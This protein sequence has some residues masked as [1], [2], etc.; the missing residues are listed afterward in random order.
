MKPVA[1]SPSNENRPRTPLMVPSV[2]MNFWKAEP[3]GYE[4][5]WAWV[6]PSAPVGAT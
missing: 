6:K 5:E 2:A 1:P 3:G 4:A